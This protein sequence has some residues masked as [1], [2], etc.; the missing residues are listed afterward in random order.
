MSAKLRPVLG[1]AALA[2]L[3]LLPLAPGLFFRPAP[4]PPPAPTLALAPPPSE[5]EVL[6]RRSRYEEAY[7]ILLK[8]GAAADTARG[9]VHQYRLAVC[10]RALGLADSALARLQRL[11]GRLPEIEDY[12]RLW[13]ARPLEQLKGAEAAAPAYEELLAE[14][15]LEAVTDSARL[16]LARL[17]ESAGDH[18]R[19]LELYRAHRAVSGPSAWLIYR[20]S[21]AQR[22][23][24]DEAGRRRSLMELMERYPADP[25]ARRVAAGFRP[26]SIDER[27]TRAQVYAR[28]RDDRA[29]PE[30]R[31]VIRNAPGHDLA[32]HAAYAL[33]RALGR[34]GQF[35]RA[36]AIYEDLYRDHGW[37]PAL[38]RLA[39]LKVRAGS[40][41]EALDDYV[42]VARRHPDH[43]LAD[44]AL[45][46]AAKAAERRGLFE[47]AG[48][49]HADLARRYPASDHA[50]DASWGAAF[51]LYCRQRFE[52]AGAGFADLGRRA[53][54]PHLVDQ[55]LYWAGKSARRLGRE[56]EA[57][58]HFDRAARG[59]PRSYYS[60]RAVS[61]GFGEARLPPPPPVRAPDPGQ[62]REPAHLRRALVLGELGLSSLAGRE[63]RLA[64][65]ANEGDA[66]ALRVLRE[67][68]EALGLPTRAMVL[69]MRLGGG[70]PEALRLYPSYYWEE[71]A[72]AA[73]E[74][75]VDPH[76]VLSVIRQ[77]SF[78]NAA[79]VSRAGAV[80]LMQI[81]PKTG[82][83]LARRFGLDPFH[84]RHL[85]DPG[86]SIQLGTRYL[87]EQVR[88][89]EDAG[90]G[91]LRVQLGLAAYN[92]GPHVARRWV[93]RFPLD[94]ED[95]F[96]ERIPYRETRLY[97]KKV[98]KSYTI[99][100]ALRESGRESSEA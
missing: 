9:A 83:K 64:E 18:D 91:G 3:L 56:E 21:Q 81:M 30:L 74:A 51:S 67:A 92:A 41:L 40:D 63:L 12:R 43:G 34:S 75:R 59:F 27:Y 19:A 98:L 17:R 78:F 97:V 20:I 16:Y 28:H 77:E 72:A 87:A 88:A 62:V 89:F 2:G 31:Q 32:P 68:Y 44:D 47:R 22:R 39:G 60:A 37:P 95:L 42:E 80:G 10:E 11:E 99:Y 82:R 53:R 57:E 85:F 52:E 6:I 15:G 48:R 23:G 65:G 14:A 5:V 79:A 35:D 46:Q 70:D 54:Q 26:R 66:A 71:V 50:E 33:G 29:I 24:G 90:G 7:A 4:A 73:L 25:L 38:Y 61:L 69:T 84:R 76:L 93:E 49:L 94:D 13:L 45:W 8:A 96:V 100:K 36:R 86:L 1:A 58:G 55:S